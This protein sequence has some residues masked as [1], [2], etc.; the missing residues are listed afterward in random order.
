M[1]PLSSPMAFR[2]PVQLIGTFWTREQFP[3]NSTE[4]MWHGLSYTPRCL[5]LSF[6]MFCWCLGTGTPP[7]TPPIHNPLTPPPIGAA[8]PPRT[9]GKSW[10]TSVFFPKRVCCLNVF[11]WPCSRPPSFTMSLYTS[12]FWR[13]RK[14]LRSH[15]QSNRAGAWYWCSV[16]SVETSTCCLWTFS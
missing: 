4:V 12:I 6:K 10:V 1:T 15:Q 9:S 11:S 7:M 16:V 2:R 5:Q 13:S 8:I 14:S 3:V